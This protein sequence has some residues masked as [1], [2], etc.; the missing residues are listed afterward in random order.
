MKPLAL[1]CAL[2]CSPAIAAEQL[3]VFSAPW[4]GACKAF[5]ADHERDPSLTGGL[6]LVTVDVE[7]QREMVR[8]YR[9]RSMPTFVVLEDGR[10]VKRQVGYQGPE[11]FRR[12]LDR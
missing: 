10:E 12:W 4:C 8:R 7:T 6:E 3:M 9:V 11:R 1:L 2:A 5:K